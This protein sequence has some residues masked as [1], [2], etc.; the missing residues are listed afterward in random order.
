M[1]DVTPHGVPEYARG[2]VFAIVVGVRTS[3]VAARMVEMVP[4]HGILRR[5]RAFVEVCS[6]AA[7][8]AH[9]YTLAVGG[10]YFDAASQQVRFLWIP[11]VKSVIPALRVDRT[12]QPHVVL[13]PTVLGVFD[14][15][16][17]ARAA[18]TLHMHTLF[19]ET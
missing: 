7:R 2:D 4:R 19:P 5:T 10:C 11:C 18:M 1:Y 9:P 12:V 15:P 14:A 8:R 13:V 6:D 17:T 16:G 3:G